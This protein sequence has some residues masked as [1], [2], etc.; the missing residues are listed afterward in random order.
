MSG[1]LSHGEREFERR[2]KALPYSRWIKTVP[3]SLPVKYDPSVE[4]SRDLAAHREL[5]LSSFT[6]QEA[7]PFVIRRP[8]CLAMNARTAAMVA[9]RG[10]ATA[11][12]RW[13]S[14]RGASYLR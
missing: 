7:P 5:I 1:F 9:G 3:Y 10:F 6:A 11:P 2:L 13:K 14:M 12:P 8:L 4:D